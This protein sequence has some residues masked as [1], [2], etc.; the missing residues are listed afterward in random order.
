MDSKRNH[1]VPG[2]DA[3]GRV[4]GGK[5]ATNRAR[6]RGGG[7]PSGGPQCR[8]TGRD[9]LQREVDEEILLEKEETI[10]ELRETV[11][12]LEM[13]MAKLEQLVRLKDNRIQRLQEEVVRLQTQASRGTS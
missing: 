7:Q 12:I 5:N 2:N 1:G 4:Q 10:Q 6:G 13:K 8:G 11:E 3:A 9:S